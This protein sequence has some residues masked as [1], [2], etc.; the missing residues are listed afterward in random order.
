MAWLYK[1]NGE[2]AEIFDLSLESMQ[3][4]VGG[5]VQIVNSYDGR[6]VFVCD[7]E[8]KLKGKPENAKATEIALN[9]GALFPDDYLVGDV[10]IAASDA[11]E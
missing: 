4:A 7:E 9:A 10:I 3:E 5:Y 6:N 2:V 11:I 8:G 1:A